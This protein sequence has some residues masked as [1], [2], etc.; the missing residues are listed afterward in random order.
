MKNDKVSWTMAA[1]KAFEKGKQRM[2]KAFVVHLLDFSKFEVAADTYN[3]GIR[4]VLSKEVYLI[5]FFREILN[6]ASTSLVAILI[7][8]DN[9]I[10]TI[11][12]AC[13]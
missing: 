8:I 12:F 1:S 5:A 13:H 6:D 2:T 3:M 7:L 4:G 9:Q 10:M 11:L